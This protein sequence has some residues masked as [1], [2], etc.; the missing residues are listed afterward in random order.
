MVH[1]TEE[2]YV[3]SPEVIGAGMH[4]AVDAAKDDVTD[5]LALASEH[6]VEPRRALD[7]ACGIGRHAVELADAGLDVDGVD[8]SP[9]Y[10]ESARERAAEAGVSDRTSFQVQD[11]RDVAALEGDYDVVLHWFAFGYYEEA[12]NEALAEALRERVAR[13][14]VL[15]MGLDN[16]DAVLGEYQGSAARLRDGVLKVE[17]SEYDPVSG[18]LEALITK[19]RTGEDGYEFVGEVTWDTRLYAPAEIRRLLERAG[20]SAVHLYGGLDGAELERTASPLVV[21]GKP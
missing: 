13:N 12:A 14:G 6:G 10:V 3:E 16:K 5:L 20:F 18:R 4:R 8:I 15:V 1:W 7:V 21:V 17:R 9:E 19:F 2:T 11:M